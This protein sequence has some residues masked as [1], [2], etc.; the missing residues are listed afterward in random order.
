M[1]PS[2]WDIE[3]MRLDQRKMPPSDQAGWV[4]EIKYDGYR[5]LAQVGD[6]PCI[7]KTR[8]GVDCTKW[9]PE[10][11]DSLATLR[12]GR[13]IIDGEIAI[14]DQVGRTDFEALQV[15]AKRKGWRSGDAAVTYCAFDLLV[16]DGRVVMS[17]KLVDRKF[18]LG[19]LLA[20]ERPHILFARHIDAAMVENPISWLYAQALVLELEG[21]VGKVADSPYVPGERTRY[22]F[23]LKRPGAVPPKRFKHKR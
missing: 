2:I 17:E 5:V 9:F 11:V 8:N 1:D 3:P 6:G 20:P 12:G 7:L 22:W 18:E 13:T 4:A 23:K 21:V 10:V 14:L 15:R 16:S 19:Q